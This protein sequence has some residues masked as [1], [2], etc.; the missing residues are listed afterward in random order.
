MNW[1]G[2]I[3]LLICASPLVAAA[4]TG[5]NPPPSEPYVPRL[6]D[7]MNAVQ[8][9][10]TKLWFAGK[11][12][13]WDLAAYEIRQLRAGL[14]EAAMLYQGIPVTNVTTMAVP[15]QAVA[16]AVEAKD[17]KKFAKL[18]A[19]LTAGCNGCH[20]SIGRGFIVM[21]VPDV[22]PFGDQQ[23]APQKP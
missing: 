22:S 4:Q 2:L 3:A 16:D 11:A 10:H 18:Y 13:N 9:R 5:V 15:V 17:A 8:I 14:V 1:R 19:D 7:I 20:Q 23:F 6:G 12:A 21:R